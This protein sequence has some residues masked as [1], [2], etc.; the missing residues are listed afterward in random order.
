M[1]PVQSILDTRDIQKDPDVDQSLKDTPSVET[2]VRH[3]GKHK[4][5]FA[6]RGPQKSQRLRVGKL[7]QVLPPAGRRCSRMRE[8]CLPIMP[9]CDPCA[10]CHCRFFN[11]ICYCWRQGRFCQK[12]S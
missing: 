5:V 7:K 12:K 3:Q 10:V 6:R 2:G 11:A 4:T 8:S 1:V 9:C